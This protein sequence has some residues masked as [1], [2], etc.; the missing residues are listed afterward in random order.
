V[1]NTYHGELLG[2]MAICLILLSVNNLHKDLVG[3]VEIVSHCL[4]A[5]NRVT[6]L[7][8]HHIPSHCRHSNILKN[9]IVNCLYLSF[10]TYHSHIKANQDDHT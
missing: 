8:R 1:A 3:S 5:L 4:S 10:T 7:P 6:F 9:I 2:L